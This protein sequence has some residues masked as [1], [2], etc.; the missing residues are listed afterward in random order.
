MINKKGHSSTYDFLNKGVRDS[1]K[2]LKE[3]NSR[4]TPEELGENE[5][6]EDSPRG[7]WECD[8]DVGKVITVPISASSIKSNVGSSLADV[9]DRNTNNYA[10][11][12]KRK[13]REKEKKLN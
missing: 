10:R 11:Y 3:R 1:H 5:M 8:N 4:M 2:E 6:F 9:S 12:E 13:E 7:L